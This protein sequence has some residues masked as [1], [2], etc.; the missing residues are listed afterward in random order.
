MSVASQPAPA[1]ALPLLYS[2][3][4]CPYAIRARLAL[5]QA[6]VAV[7]TVEVDLKH[8]PAALLAASPAG[9][10]PVLVLPGGEVLAQSLDIMRWALA[11]SDPD[12][13]LRPETMVDEEFWIKTTDSAFKYWLDRYKYFERHPAHPQAHYRQQA[14]DCLLAPLEHTL[15]THG[16]WLGGAQPVLADAAVFPFV[17][18]FA[19]VEPAWWTSRPLASTRAWLHAWLE[20]PVFLGVM[21]KQA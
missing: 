1:S 8:K 17:R 7:H 14:L 10:V 20:S 11:Q 21:H 4:R 13:W 2:F 6:G 3:R 19:G 18:Q 5:A 16:P 9:T 15:S 12:G